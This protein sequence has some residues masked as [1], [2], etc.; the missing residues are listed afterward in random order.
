MQGRNPEADEQKAK[1]SAAKDWAARE[2]VKDCR[3]KKRVSL[4][5]GTQVSHGRHLSRPRCSHLLHL[6]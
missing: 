5:H 6:L 1:A 3:A 4:T 2:L